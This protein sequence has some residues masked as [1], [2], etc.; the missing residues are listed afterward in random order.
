MLPYTPFLRLDGA[1]TFTLNPCFRIYM[2]SS[3][4]WLQSNSRFKGFSR[5]YLLGTG[6]VVCLFP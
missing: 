5:L 3:G 2:T 4:S 6:G 1:S